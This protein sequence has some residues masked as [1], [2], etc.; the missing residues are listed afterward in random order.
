MRIALPTG[1]AL[2]PATQNLTKALGTIPT[3]GFVGATW[4]VKATAAR[5]GSA[6]IQFTG[7]RGRTVKFTVTEA[8]APAGEYGEL[9][10]I[11][12]V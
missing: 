7:P 8:A 11:V 4:T 9:M 1:L 2:E 10:V 5:P 3:N 6:V 12:A